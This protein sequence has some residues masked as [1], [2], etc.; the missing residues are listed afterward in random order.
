FPPQREAL[1]QKP[2]RLLVI[3]LPPRRITQVVERRRDPTPVADLPLE[4]QAL[5]QEPASFGVVTQRHRIAA[6]VEEGRGDP[7]DVAELPVDRQALLI[8][9]MGCRVI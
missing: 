2:A 3:P 4:A 7:R 9:R 1:A 6:E 8:T 5:F